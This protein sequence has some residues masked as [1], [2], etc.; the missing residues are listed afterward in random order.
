MDKSLLDRL[1]RI[2]DDLRDIFDDAK[3]LYL[4]ANRHG[5]QVD[6]V[7]FSYHLAKFDEQLDYLGSIIDYLAE[8]EHEETNHYNA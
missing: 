1:I 7:K 8:T 5:G 3:F 2:E 6:L 4:D